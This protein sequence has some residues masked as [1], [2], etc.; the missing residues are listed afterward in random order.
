MRKTIYTAITAALTIAATYTSGG[1]ARP[2]TPTVKCSAAET[3]RSYLDAAEAE[4]CFKGATVGVL[5][6]TADGDTVLNKNCGRLMTPA[7]NLKLL[8][9]ALALHSLGGDFRYGTRIGYSGNISNG[10][11]DGDLYIIGGGDPTLCSSNPDAV[12]MK[13]TFAKWLKFIKDAGIKEIGGYVI[14]DGRVFPGMPEQ[15]SWQLNDS[16]TYYGTG[17]SGLS[18]NE[19]IQSFK[20]SPG[21]KPGDPLNISPLYPQAPWMEYIY[22]CTTGKKGTGNTL[23]FYTSGLAPVGEMR[24]TFA[25]D[26][27]PKTE[28]AANKFPEYTCACY[29]TEYLKNNGIR[30]RKGP[31]DLGNVFSP[32][33]DEWQACEQD[34][35][36]ITGSTFSPELSRIIY[37]ANRE[38]NNLYAEA[39]MKTLGMEYCGK[40]CYDSAYVAVNGILSELGINPSGIKIRD[41]SGLSRE[42]LVSPEFLCRLLGAMTDSPEFENYVE[43]LPF[44]GGEGTLKYMMKS[45]PETTKARIRMKSGSMGGVRC[46]SG[47]IIPRSGSKEDTIIFSVMV[48]GFTAPLSRIQQRLDRL[49]ALLAETN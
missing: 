7:S 5:A 19:N 43:S 49:I 26:R 45:V 21:E 11:L 1:Q 30:C 47:Y 38:S 6:V 9:T 25:V 36:S 8:T 40:G 10:R 18:F 23:Y 20:V 13:E 28:E 17:V 27:K 2:S 35:L 32:D 15:E 14:G 37:T 12:P 46:F 33:P 42:N 41:G 4:E 44:P 29:F 39:L 22:S 3:V 48:N 34:N 31:A 24:G 16:G